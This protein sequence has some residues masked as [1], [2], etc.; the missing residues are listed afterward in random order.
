MRNLLQKYW[1]AGVISLVVIGLILLALSGY[2]APFYKA[3]LNPFVAAQSWLATRYLAVY[4]MISS[5]ADV[6]QLRTENDQ[7]KRENATLRSQLIQLQEQQKDDEI[8][9]SLLRAARAQP[10]SVYIAARVIGRDS[11]PFLRYLLI[12]QGSDKGLIQ[13]MPVIT[14]QGLVG[15]IDAVIATAARVQLIIDSNSAVN[16][17]LPD[18]GADAMLEGSVTGDMTLEMISQEV[19][20]KPGELIL[21]SGLGG[22]YPSN[23]LVGQVSSVRKLETA[24]SSVR[25]L[26]TALF[27]SASVQP[28]VD[29]ANLQIVLVVTNF[30]P[31]DLETLNL[32]STGQ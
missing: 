21:T 4:E 30:E 1:R 23:I 22:T 16:V 11:S 10:T 20:V 5:P 19:D 2:L 26:E 3:A 28:V 27:Q 9:Y 25:K 7:L 15:R 18:S 24:L 13:G 32:E 12:D 8:V 17:H 14:E 29:F 6:N 31:V